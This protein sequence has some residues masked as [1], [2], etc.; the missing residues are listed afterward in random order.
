MTNELYEKIK[1]EVEA[2]TERRGKE[3][4]YVLGSKIVKDITYLEAL[5]MYY[6]SQDG[7]IVHKNELHY[8]D[9]EN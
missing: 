6:K 9:I 3:Y 8:L 5:D 7:F 1:Q 2:S 4:C